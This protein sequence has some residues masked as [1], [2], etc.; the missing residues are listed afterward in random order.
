MGIDFTAVLG[1]T[2]D[3]E[4][5]RTLPHRLSAACSPHLSEAI[6]ELMTCKAEYYSKYEAKRPTLD[7]FSEGGW[8]VQPTRLALYKDETGN[9]TP[10]MPQPVEEDTGTGFVRVFLPPVAAWRTL[11]VE[12]NWAAGNWFDVQGYIG[13]AIGPC[14]LALSCWP[15]WWTFLTA[16]KVQ[17]V[18]RRVCYEL[19]RV[20]GSPQALY[21]ADCWDPI[22]AIIAGATIEQ[23][24]AQLHAGLGAPEPALTV[25]SEDTAGDAIRDAYYLDSFADL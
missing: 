2:I 25:L 8:Y 3:P 18:T 20:V 22:D 14:T 1:H 17:E 7:D 5:L 9:L 19:A 24:V 12:E 4:Q 11:S 16:P 23:I 6:I 15:R 10:K 13:L 21:L